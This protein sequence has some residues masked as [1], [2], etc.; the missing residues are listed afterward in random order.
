M[1]RLNS[2]AMFH[3]TDRFLDACDGDYDLARKALN[4]A[5]RRREKFREEVIT[6][7][8]QMFQGKTTVSAKVAGAVSTAI[9]APYA[10]VLRIIQKEFET[11]RGAG[12]HIQ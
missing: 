12:V 4:D 6:I 10:K 9:H 2:E 1:S 7:T 11:I 3:L 8:K 5:F